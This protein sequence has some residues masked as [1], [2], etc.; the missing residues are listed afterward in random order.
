MQQTT[1]LASV[2]YDQA[3]LPDIRA[4]H[5][6]EYSAGVRAQYER[7]AAELLRSGADEHLARAMARYRLGQ[8]SRAAVDAGR[9]AALA[10]APDPVTLHHASGQSLVVA[11]DDEGC[12]TASGCEHTEADLAA[13]L[14]VVP[15]FVAA[16]QAAREAFFRAMSG[17]SVDG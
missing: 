1:E 17:A 11:V 10:A 4:A 5:G 2:Y 3:Y 12:I 6:H 16:A 13:A 9:R 8:F 7:Q 15:A 14:R